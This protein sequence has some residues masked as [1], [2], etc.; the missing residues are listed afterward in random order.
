[1]GGGGR[2]RAAGFL[3]ASA[4]LVLA[5]L[6]FT[7]A[8]QR[9]FSPGPPHRGTSTP[10]LQLPSVTRKAAARAERLAFALRHSARRFLAAFF[11]YEVGEGGRRLAVALRA[12]ATPAFTRRLL[13]APPRAASPAGYPPPARPGDLRVAFLSASADRALVSGAARRGG[14]AEQFSFV[15]E[16][17]GATWLASGPGQ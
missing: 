3:L 2:W 16:R 10:A 5:A 4:A 8:R 12:S 17:H 13:G 7:A 1:M 9:E 14:L 6:A 11:R 15:F